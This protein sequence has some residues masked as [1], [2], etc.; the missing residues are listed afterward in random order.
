MSIIIS[1]LS[2]HYPNQHNLFEHINFSVEKHTKVAIVGDNGVGKSTLLKTISGQLAPTEGNIVHTS[3]PY[4]LPQHTGLLYKTVAEVLCVSKKLEALNAIT[5]GSVSQKDYDT[6]NDDWDIEAKCKS[7]LA[8]WKLSHLQL[9]ASIDTLS[10][11]EKTK[12]FLAGLLIHSPEIILLDEPSNHL[13]AASRKILYQFIRQST[14]TIVVV[15]HDRML[16]DQ[17]HTIYELS[18][19]QIKLYGGNYS[20]YIEQKEIEDNALNNSIH[21]EE[22]V[23]RLAR[24]RAREV[25]QKQEKLASK[26]EK[27][28]FEVP[29]IFRKTLTNST[30]NTTAKLNDKHTKIISESQSKLS[31]LRQ[32]QRALKELKINFEH[33]TIHR[34]KVLIEAHQ[35]NYAYQAD[36]PLWNTP[37]DLKLYSNDRICIR[38]NNGSGKSTLIKMLIGTLSP[39]IGEVKQANFNWVYLDQ[40]YTVV[41]T[42]ATIVELANSYNSQNLPEH[43]VKLRLN[44]FLFPAD[45]WD[46]RCHILSGGEKMRLYLCCLMI[47][48]QNPDLIM[49]DEPTNNLDIANMQILTRTIKDYQGALLVIS[50]DSYFVKE[51][52]ITKEVYV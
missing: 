51:I 40:D 24:K 37:I 3:L 46:K 15:S 9:D 4:Y 13:D 5:Q 23:L 29:R 36:N 1:D 2:Y 52:G 12:V 21:C 47:S 19:Q 48:R 44:R 39:C 31:E 8:Y 7:A 11:G 27:S 43:E 50:H 38:G 20:F 34:G 18:A 16:L 45:T 33:A 22:K 6:L 35:I 26:G 28:K 10:G 42:D 14:S 32:Q 49:L 17:L 25:K 30:E 41:N